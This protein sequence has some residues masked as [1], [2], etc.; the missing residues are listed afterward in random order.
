MFLHDP[1]FDFTLPKPSMNYIHKTFLIRGKGSLLYLRYYH[2]VRCTLLQGRPVVRNLSTVRQQKN[3]QC[4]HI[5]YGSFDFFFFP[6]ILCLKNRVGLI[7]GRGL[8]TRKYGIL[9]R[10]NS[11]KLGSPRSLSASSRSRVSF[12]SVTDQLYSLLAKNCMVRLKKFS[13]QWHPKAN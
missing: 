9:L 10:P 6:Q 11:G 8:Y 4:W 5:C 12:T 7:H 13:L 3:L 1:Y 2:P